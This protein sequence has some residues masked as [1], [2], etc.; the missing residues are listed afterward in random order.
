MSLKKI[1]MLPSP[2]SVWEKSPSYEFFWETVTSQWRLKTPNASFAGL[3]WNGLGTYPRLQLSNV[4]TQDQWGAQD[5]KMCLQ[6]SFGGGQHQWQQPHCISRCH[7]GQSAKESPNSQCWQQGPSLWH[8][9]FSGEGSAVPTWLS[10]GEIAALVLV[11]IF[12]PATLLST[13]VVPG[14]SQRGLQ[15][16]GIYT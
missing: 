15:E 9:L 2:S 5:G 4:P 6:G 13:T 10:C 3:L 11:P 1:F 7:S 16:T 14:N 12:C 8:R